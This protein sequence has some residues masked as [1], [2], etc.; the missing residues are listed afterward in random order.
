MAAHGSNYVL[1]LAGFPN[2]EAL[3]APFVRFT[4]QGSYV[5]AL[6]DSKFGQPLNYLHQRP[7][8]PNWLVDR[9]EYKRDGGSVCFGGH[10]NGPVHT[11]LRGLANIFLWRTQDMLIRLISK[12]PHQ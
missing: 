10:E 12:Q 7:E 5:P 9:I 11:A 4:A 3:G 1:L 2:P 8:I 6:R